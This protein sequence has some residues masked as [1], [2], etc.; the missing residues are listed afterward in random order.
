MRLLLDTHLLIWAVSR[1]AKLSAVFR[2]IL[3]RPTT[4]IFYSAASIW[5]IATKQA[6]GLPDFDIP[7][8]ELD[9]GARA[10]AFVEIPVRAE[11]AAMVATMPLHHRDP[12]DRLLIAQA[13][14]ADLV[15]YTMDRKLRLY[16]A[17]VT[18]VP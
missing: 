8:H 15:F 1:S 3:E 10:A 11:V 4:S 6:L 16:G 18:P 12:F 17:P 13:R 9:E 14:A 2:D 7:P 5:E